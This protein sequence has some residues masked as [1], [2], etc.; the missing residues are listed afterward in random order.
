MSAV[1][2]HLARCSEC[3]EVYREMFPEVVQI[4][5][6]AVLL[7]ID[8]KQ[9]E[10][11]HLEYD[12]HLEPFVEGRISAVDREI[13]EGHIKT[14]GHCSA[15]LRDLQEFR[16]LLELEDSRDEPGVGFWERVTA[17]VRGNFRILTFAAAVILLVSA[18]IAIYRGTQD[19][20]SINIS[21]DAVVPPV[22]DDSVVPS[23]DIV[24]QTEPGNPSKT[25]SYDEPM[26][27]EIA[28][29]RLPAFLK[30]LRAARPRNLRSESDMR[31]IT[32]IRPNGIVVR[33]V[34]QMRWKAIAGA[35]KYEVAI[36][37]EKDQKI[38]GSDSVRTTIWQP[39]NLRRG[40][41]YQWQVAAASGSDPN[42][43][44]IG[45]GKFYLTSEIEESRIA[46]ARD[47]LARGKALA[48]A[49]LIR[50]AQVEFRDYLQKF[51][52]STAARK[53]LTQTMQAR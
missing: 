51:P 37:D 47:A 30:D 14:C 28:A 34:P 27:T 9:F 33:T 5:R 6:R 2:L 42:V 26:E 43:R 3:M 38:T 7:P 18:G 15:M 46:T 4:E 39:T 50:E 32:V 53:Y 17:A 35:E 16:E 11:F 29:L 40:Q 1:V 23:A 48:E 31:E 41:I 22:R 8:E 13:V 10:V 25:P 20:N 49:G 45:Q 12:E 36:F 24:D 19:T 21:A 52:S 44:F